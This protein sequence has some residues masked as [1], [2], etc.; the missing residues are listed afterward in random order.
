L[1]LIDPRSVSSGSKM[2]AYAHL[3]A[4]G[5]QRGDD[6]VAY[7]AS[8][9]AGREARR[10][11]TIRS[12]V[13][14]A[15]VLDDGDAARGAALFARFCAPCHGA[16]A[17]GDGPVGRAFNA[18]MMDLHKP[19]L[20]LV[21]IVAGP[22]GEPVGL[23]RLVKFGWPGRSMPGHEYFSDEQIGDLVAHVRSLRGADP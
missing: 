10:M 12:Y 20:W 14:P 18:E 9:G 22:D 7:L 1:H 3:F 5:S 11:A 23:A 13:P 15:G 19:E 6:L 17:S 2:P 4:G 21:P 16:T 8:L